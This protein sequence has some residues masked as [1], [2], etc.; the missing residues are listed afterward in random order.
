[1]LAAIVDLVPSDGIH[2]FN[3]KTYAENIVLVPA[4]NSKCFLHT[5]HAAVVAGL[6][7]YS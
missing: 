5:T 4:V 6:K 3:A 2:V 1:M 7:M